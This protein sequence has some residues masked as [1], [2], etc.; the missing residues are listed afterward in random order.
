MDCIFCKIVNDEIPSYTIFED[1]IVR[2]ILD[3]KPNSDGHMLILTKKHFDNIIDI[4]L[5]TWNHV[6]VVA[7]QMYKLL[8]EKLNVDGVT[9]TVNNDY[10]QDI[11][12]FHMHLTPRYNKDNIK[13]I[14]PNEKRDIKEIFNILTK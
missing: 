2:V 11:K 10:G 13:I 9:I 8:K 14:Y 7:K 4:D 1:K 3:I 6:N 5:D 12:H